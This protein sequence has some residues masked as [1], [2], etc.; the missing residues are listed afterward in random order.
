MCRVYFLG[1]ISRYFDKRRERSRQAAHTLSSLKS[2]AYAAIEPHPQWPLGT[3]SQGSAR[4]WPLA[5]RFASLWVILGG[6]LKKGS[7]FFKWGPFPW[8][9][10]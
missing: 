2:L 10:S 7:G 3:K 5:N 8:H 4:K 9:E 6:N 1:P